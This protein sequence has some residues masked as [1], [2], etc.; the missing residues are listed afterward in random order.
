MEIN[1]T[2][3]AEQPAFRVK[4]EDPRERVLR[5]YDFVNAKRM[6]NSLTVAEER[7]PDGA[8]DHVIATLLAITVEEVEREN[9]EITNKLR[10]LMKV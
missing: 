10:R 6:N 1:E 9:K 7:Y 4:A 5:K 2:N 8:P 3:A